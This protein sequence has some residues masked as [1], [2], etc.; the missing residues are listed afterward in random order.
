MFGKLGGMLKEQAMAQLA[1]ATTGGDHGSSSGQPVGDAPSFS[2]INPNGKKKA[3][4][5]GI[6]YTG[7]SAALR[8]CWNDVK[9][10]SAFVFK[11][12]YKPENSLFLTDE[13]TDAA[14]LP[15]H[16]NI[17]NGFNW[18]A[19]GAVAGDALFL[20]YSGHGGSQPDTDG[21][22]LDG[23]DETIVPVDYTKSGMIVDDEIYAHLV[24]NLPEG[25]RLTAVFDSCHSGSVLDLAFAYRVDG[26]LDIIE[27]DLRK[28]AFGKALEAGKHYLSGNKKGAFMSVRDG[29]QL[30]LLPPQK[31]QNQAKVEQMRVV[32]AD[33]VQFS[34]CR[35]DQTSADANISG[36]ATGAMSYALMDALNK[37]HDHLTYTGLL[38][39]LRTILAGKFSQV[40][41]MT[42]GRRVNMNQPFTF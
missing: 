40:P 9:N 37:N 39:T 23:M 15:T 34:G 42:A 33:V 5:I 3:L 24:K 14:H 30:L 1:T 22:E 38:Q 28:A 35:D 21:D 41:Q 6:N 32:R 17:L 16:A 7:S 27:T 4:F 31:N 10:V 25:V 19:Q 20:H 18:L 8:G 11:H 12:G 26:N 29:V 36:S 13:Q 2:P